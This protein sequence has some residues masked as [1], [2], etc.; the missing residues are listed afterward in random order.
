MFLTFFTWPNRLPC[1]LLIYL[2]PC[3][4]SVNTFEKV[5]YFCEYLWILL[6]NFMI[7]C[8]TKNEKKSLVSDGKVTITA[9]VGGRKAARS[10]VAWLQTKNPCETSVF[11][12]TDVKKGDEN[13][14]F[15]R[16]NS[17]FEHFSAENCLKTPENDA[18]DGRNG[19][20]RHARDGITWKPMYNDRISW[21]QSGLQAE[22]IAFLQNMSSFCC[23]IM[24][25]RAN[26]DEFYGYQDDSYGYQCYQQ[27]PRRYLQFGY[28][29][30][31]IRRLSRHINL[32]N[33]LFRMNFG[34]TVS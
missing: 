27:L 10:P 2:I 8:A 15:L 32:C 3:R 12:K 23:F 33:V 25:S 6:C 18:A 14:V 16:K 4:G 11:E 21:Y 20:E 30:V 13:P 17:I 19:T 9:P 24:L 1:D 22:L 31:D 34:W 7:I 26:I 5:E 29:S 28:V